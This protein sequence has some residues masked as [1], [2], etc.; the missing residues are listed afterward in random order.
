MDRFPE[1]F[2]I[3]LAGLTFEQ[4]FENHPKWI[5]CVA[6]NWTD[7]CTG[8]FKKFRNYVL[9][10]LKDDLSRIEHEQRCYKYVRTLDQS[11]LPPYLIKYS[12]VFSLKKTKIHI[13]KI[14]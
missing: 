8:L 4:I 11:N 3:E 13:S 10:R 5:A 9:L 1:N 12:H 7:N 2:G 14:N 6:D